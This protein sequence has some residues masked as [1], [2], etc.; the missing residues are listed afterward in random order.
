MKNKFEFESEH[1]RGAIVTA[2]EEIKEGDR[3]TPGTQDVEIISIKYHGQ[4][5][6][7]DISGELYS[8]IEEELEKYCTL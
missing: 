3:V 4:D 5:I 7:N 6:V 8:M 2:V 1:L